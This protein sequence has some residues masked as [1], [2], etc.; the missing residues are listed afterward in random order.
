MIDAKTLKVLDTSARYEFQRIFDPE[1]TAIHIQQSIP[2]DKLA[3]LFTNFV[4]RSSARGLGEALP[5]VEIGDLK[6]VGTQPAKPK[7]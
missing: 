6:I 2:I 3:D 5:S 4:E 1:S 7:P